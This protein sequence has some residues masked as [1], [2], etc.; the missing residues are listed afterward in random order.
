MPFRLALRSL[1][2][3]PGLAVAAVVLL[4]LGIGATTA[5]FSVVNTVL[6]SPLPYKEPD[7]L[8]REVGPH[9]LV[10]ARRRRTLR[11]H[12]LA[13]PL[14]WRRPRVPGERARQQHP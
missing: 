3:S 10:A 7:R 12:L 4:A 13:R 2:R 8:V 5:V 1:S 14:G 9:P 6:L 11:R